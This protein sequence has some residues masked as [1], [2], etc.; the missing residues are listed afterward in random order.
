M[1][2][3]VRQILSPVKHMSQVILC[4]F[5]Q[6]SSEAHHS[7]SLVSK[8]AGLPRMPCLADFR[9][10]GAGT[11]YFQHSRASGCH[12]S[13]GASPIALGKSVI[14]PTHA[15]TLF[16]RHCR[17]I[18]ADKLA[19]KQQAIPR[20]TTC[21]YLGRNPS[22]QRQPYRTHELSSRVFHTKHTFGEIYWSGCKRTT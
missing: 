9:V 1:R 17:F 8:R 5:A 15:A 16:S 21:K 12:P 18:P 2:F 11:M 4:D 10:N 20:L 13:G 22:I 19:K 3:W 7:L 6:S 14:P